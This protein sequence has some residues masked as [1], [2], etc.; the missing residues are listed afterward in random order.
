MK[1][2]KPNK[3]IK[4]GPKV[5]KTGEIDISTKVD[6]QCAGHWRLE[7]LEATPRGGDDNLRVSKFAKT[8]LR[9]PA[10]ERLLDQRCQIVQTSTTVVL[11]GQHLRKKL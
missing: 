5:H 9:A 6:Q 2:K 4:S 8:A 1:T 11:Q 7:Y 3:S 10:A